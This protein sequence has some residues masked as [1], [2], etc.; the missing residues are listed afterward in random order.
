MNH[1]TKMYLI[2]EG[3]KHALDQYKLKSNESCALQ[4]QQ[5]QQNESVSE[6]EKSIIELRQQINQLQSP[7]AAPTSVSTVQAE[8]LPEVPVVPVKKEEK[9]KQK[10]RECYKQLEECR[11]K[12]WQTL[13]GEHYSAIPQGEIPNTK[14]LSTLI[15]STPRPKRE[16]KATQRLVL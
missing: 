9:C 10:L 15:T 6:L 12:Q 3:D 13:E 5:Q 16:R 8:A 14:R 11:I 2:T 4:Q 7:V 1:Y